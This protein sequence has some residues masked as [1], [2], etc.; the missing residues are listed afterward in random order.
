MS[1][2]KTSAALPGVK[3]TRSVGNHFDCVSQDFDHR[4]HSA[5]LGHDRAGGPAV[6]NLVIH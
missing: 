5:T 4:I 2:R 6:F 3:L 1:L